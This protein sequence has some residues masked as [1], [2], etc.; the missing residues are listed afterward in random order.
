SITR[1]HQDDLGSPSAAVSVVRKLKCVLRCGSTEVGDWQGRDQEFTTF[2]GQTAK[3]CYRDWNRRAECECPGKR[4]SAIIG[5]LVEELCKLAVR[6]NCRAATAQVAALI[7]EEERH[8][9]R[10]IVRI[11]NRKTR[12]DGPG[13]LGIDPARL[14]RGRSR[15]GGFGHKNIVL[16]QAEDR[17]SRWSRASVAGLN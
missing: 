4:R 8:R 7:C 9:C 13:D 3:C 12:V 15:H 10:L 6:G 2:V 17:E 1:I 11:R 14:D 16:T 5:E